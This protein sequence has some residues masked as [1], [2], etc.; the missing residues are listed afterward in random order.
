MY[1]K[2]NGIEFYNFK[3]FIKSTKETNPMYFSS[4][5]ISP[6]EVFHKTTFCIK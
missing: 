2:K 1:N 4:K 6:M 3:N 5:C